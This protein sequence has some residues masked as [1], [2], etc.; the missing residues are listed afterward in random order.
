[1]R[2]FLNREVAQALAVPGLPRGV[3][4]A[5][6]Q[7]ACVA[8]AGPSERVAPLLRPTPIAES[9]AAIAGVAQPKLNSASSAVEESVRLRRQ[10]APS[11]RFLD[12][13]LELW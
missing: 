12:L 11:R 10:E 7:A 9:L 13:E 3:Q 6:S 2:H 4:P 1:M 5:R 8:H